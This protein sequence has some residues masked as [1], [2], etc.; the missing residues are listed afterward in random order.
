MRNGT[1]VLCSLFS[2]ITYIFFSGSIFFTEMYT[3]MISLNESLSCS[4]L[5]SK[6]SHRPL[7][8]KLVRNFFCN[9]LVL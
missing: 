3:C 7:G 2:L 1:E 5:N 8:L 9:M 4:C 6:I